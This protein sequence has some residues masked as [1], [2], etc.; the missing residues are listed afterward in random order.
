MSTPR[1]QVASSDDLLLTSTP[2]TVLTGVRI[3]PAAT[4]AS[5]AL[6]LNSP[7]SLSPPDSIMASPSLRATLDG[8]AMLPTPP[9]SLPTSYSAA[10]LFSPSPATEH[11][12]PGEPALVRGRRD[13]DLVPG[14]GRRDERRA[15]TPPSVYG[16]GC[17]GEGGE[18]GEGVAMDLEGSHGLHLGLVVAPHDPLAPPDGLFSAAAR[19]PRPFRSRYASSSNDSLASE[20]PA[21]DSRDIALGDDAGTPHKRSHS[22]VLPSTGNTPPASFDE[23]APAMPFPRPETLFKPPEPS[24]G[25]GMSPHWRRSFSYDLQRAEPTTS[26]SVISA[27]APAPLGHSAAAAPAPL[28]MSILRRRARAPTES[29]PTPS[30]SSPAAHALSPRAGDRVSSKRRR[31]G[32]LSMSDLPGAGSA[33]TSTSTSRLPPWLASRGTSSALPVLSRSTSTEDDVRTIR[34]RGRLSLACFPGTAGAAVELEQGLYARPHVSASHPPVADSSA[35]ALL[36]PTQQHQAYTA[37]LQHAARSDAL[38]T[39][40]EGLLREAADVLARAEEH[41]ARVAVVVSARGMEQSVAQRS[42]GIE[43]LR[44][45]RDAA[46]ARP[47]VGICLGEG[48]ARTA[49]EVEPTSPTSPRRRRSSLWSRSSPPP[50]AGASLSPPLDSSG[51]SMSSSSSASSRARNFLT[52]LRARRPRLSRNATA[53]TPPEAAPTSPPAFS[54]TSTFATLSTRASSSTAAIRGW[55]LPSPPLAATLASSAF[56]EDAELAAADRLNRRLLE[57]RRVSESIDLGA[58]SGSSAPSHAQPETALW[59]E[60]SAREAGEAESGRGRRLRGPTQSANERW[61]FGPS[62]ATEPSLRSSSATN[63]TE[64][65]VPAAHT[66]LSTPAWRR[67]ARSA[68]GIDAGV[69]TGDAHFAE[70]A[71]DETPSPRRERFFSAAALRAA[72]EGVARPPSRQVMG[73]GRPAIRLARSGAGAA[74]AERSASRPRLLFDDDDGADADAARAAAAWATA[75]PPL[76]AFMLPSGSD[77]ARM[78]FPHP[79]AA[80]GSVN[81]REME[82]QRSVSPFGTHGPDHLFTAPSTTPRDELPFSARRPMPWDEM[83]SS[84]FA[85]RRFAES[86]SDPLGDTSTITTTANAGSLSSSAHNAAP[87][88]SSLADALAHFDTRATPA[89]AGPGEASLRRRRGPPAS[90]GDGLETPGIPRNVD[91]AASRENRFRLGPDPAHRD[92]DTASEVLFRRSD[93][94]VEERLAQHRQSRMDRLQALR[95]ERHAMRTLLGVAIAPASPYAADAESAPSVAGPSRSPGAGVGGG[96]GRLG[97]FLR[98]LGGGARY[99]FV[100]GR[101]GFGGL[102]DDDFHAFWGRDSAALDPRNY[103]DDDEFDTSYEALL[104]LSEQLGDVKPKGVSTVG[105]A[106]LRKFKYCAWPL[107]ASSS[108]PPPPPHASTSAL[109][110]D[111]PPGLGLARKGL[112]KEVRCGICLCDYEDDD[113]CMLG[114]CEHGFHEEC[115]VSWLSQKGTCP[116]CR[117]DHAV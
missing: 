101:G 9:A 16:E 8:T 24:D 117:R 50:D 73:M 74:T 26:M 91:G 114:T 4:H 15:S 82:R 85:S 65:A 40:G 58:V 81:A 2:S 105:L 69:A 57:R 37:L 78:L 103:L 52:Q 100:G 95:R 18:G 53:V 68:T 93:A 32:T 56:D 111:P 51:T 86:H 33:T 48:W 5:G 60:P 13:T 19:I 27:T 75:Q 55:T 112:E 72:E 96:R 17:G 61:R 38:A 30:S 108:S 107:R 29:D 54:R 115:L 110:F 98:G 64:T 49:P 45:L 28:S 25:P 79:P 14:G 47:A 104:R 20:A 77:G 116:V 23:A 83:P 62:V 10:P 22:Q 87:G 43:G 36:P 113:D 21:Q 31:S 42:P 59:G 7:T 1:P 63:V 92:T 102:W 94:T 41:V 99:N 46:S 109:S 35:P 39:R 90:S 88:R 66:R 84:W 80:A 67:F 12:T 70:R 89:D 6:A 34:R 97:E 76:R 71:R 11:A 106:A 44:E 3:K